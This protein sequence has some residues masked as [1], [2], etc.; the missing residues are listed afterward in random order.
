MVTKKYVFVSQF[1]CHSQD[2]KNIT[3]EF[4]PNIQD[5]QNNSQIKEYTPSHFEACSVLFTYLSSLQQ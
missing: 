4:R 3:L 5:A 2:N 1:G